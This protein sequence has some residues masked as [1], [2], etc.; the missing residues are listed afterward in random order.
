MLSVFVIMIAGC[1]HSGASC[2]QVEESRHT[3]RDLAACEA[4]L[5]RR[6]SE[7]EAE[8]PVLEGRCIAAEPRVA[9]STPLPPRR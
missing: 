6:L 4:V 3:V 2:T 5:D 7:I 1:D 9:A 8:W